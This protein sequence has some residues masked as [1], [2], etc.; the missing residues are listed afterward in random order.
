MKMYEIKNLLKMYKAGDVP[1]TWVSRE[2]RAIGLKES[3]IENELI[4]N[5]NVRET[6]SYFSRVAK[7]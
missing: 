1:Y 3:I 6:A 5:F 7:R 2:L 4:G